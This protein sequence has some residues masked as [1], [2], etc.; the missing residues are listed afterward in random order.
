MILSFTPRIS[1]VLSSAYKSCGAFIT[2]MKQANA[3]PRFWNVSFVGS[4]ALVDE[5]G[6]DNARG[7]EISQVVPFPWSTGIPI[8]TEYPKKSAMSAITRSHR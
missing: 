1:A 5:L 2:A 3:Y 7:A 8:V 6:N 4:K